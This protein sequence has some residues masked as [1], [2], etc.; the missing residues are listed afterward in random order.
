M[1]PINKLNKKARGVILGLVFII[2]ALV[3][4]YV[5]WLRLQR[6]TYY[7]GTPEF[8][9]YGNVIEQEKC[10]TLGINLHGEIV[11][12]LPEELAT[13]DYVSA[14]DVIYYIGSIKDGSISSIPIEAIVLDIDSAGGSPVAAEEI[15]RAIKE[16]GLP[17]VAVIRDVGASAGYWIA[18]ASE[19]IFASKMSDI[20]SIGVTMSYL[21]ESKL[22]AT[23]GYTWNSLSTGKFKDMG[24]AQKPLTKEERDIFERDLKIMYEEFLHAVS[25]NRKMPLEEVRGLA[26]GS[27]MLGEMAKEKGLIDEIGSMQEAKEYL[28]KTHNI[29]PEICWY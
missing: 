16:S 10:N 14:D 25:T 18:S 22:N 21:D 24:S 13:G 17:S 2:V 1:E 29:E 9:E 5:F 3:A 23:D 28:K 26:D 8:D 15:S 11:T 20:G 27:A 6:V 12:Y 4:V 19:Y 7:E